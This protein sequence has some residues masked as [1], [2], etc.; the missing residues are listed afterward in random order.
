MTISSRL[1]TPGLTAPKPPRFFTVGGGAEDVDGPLDGAPDAPGGALGAAGVP[2]DVGAG[3]GAGAGDG[4]DGLPPPFSWMSIGVR[5]R[6][7][8]SATHSVLFEASRRPL[9]VR[10]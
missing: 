2:D 10:P 7:R 4:F 8:S 9:T 1:R 6:L 3:A 5:L